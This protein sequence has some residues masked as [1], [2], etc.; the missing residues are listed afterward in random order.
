MRNLGIIICAL[1]IVSFSGR[2][3]AGCNTQ[4]GLISNQPDTAVIIPAPDEESPDTPPNSGIGYQIGVSRYDN[5]TLLI[6][7]SRDLTD[8]G[9]FDGRLTSGAPVIGVRFENLPGFDAAKH[10]NAIQPILYKP[11]IE[12][13]NQG[14]IRASVDRG[15]FHIEFDPKAPPGAWVVDP[16]PSHQFV[17]LFPGRFGHSS[18]GKAWALTRNYDGAYQNVPVGSVKRRWIAEAFINLALRQ[19]RQLLMAKGFPSGRR[20]SRQ[21]LAQV[22]RNRFGPICDEHAEHLLCLASALIEENEA[23]P[24][25]DFIAADAFRVGD[26]IY[27]NSGVSTGIRQLD[28]G[29][30]NRQAADLVVKLLPATVGRYKPGY[31]Y[32]RAIRKWSV[33]ELNRWYETDGPLAN[34]ELSRDEAKNILL[35]S[36]PIFLQGTVDYWQK[37]VDAVYPNWP[38]NEKTALSLL[39]IDMENVTG[40]PLLLPKYAKDICIV[41]GSSERWKGS[42]NSYVVGRQARRV[43]NGLKML[44]NI[45]GMPDLNWSC[46]PALGVKLPAAPASPLPKLAT[47]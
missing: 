8:L 18:A 16:D 13:L 44:W 26:A 30:S 32:R 29:T 31:G 4:S 9:K 21:D 36:H 40:R 23:A 7:L 33:T 1:S 28:F 22:T 15:R 25:G 27:E 3:W 2:A 12:R 11:R 19:H 45:K 20:P 10:C 46:L 42:T 17:W 41:L 35:E 14:R 6:D 47:H 37:Q 24:P 43:Q 34:S 5:Q 38:G 39:A